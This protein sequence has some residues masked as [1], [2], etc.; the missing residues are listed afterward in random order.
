[1]FICRLT[2]LVKCLLDKQKVFLRIPYLFLEQPCSK[3]DEREKKLTRP[4][5]N[6]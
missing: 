5:Y 3:N 4:D 6:V 1:M 2:F